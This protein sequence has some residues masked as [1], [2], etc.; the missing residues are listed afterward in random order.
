[1]AKKGNKIPPEKFAGY[2][3]LIRSVPAVKL[4]G[5]ANPYTSHN[6]H[7]F[8]FQDANGAVGIRLPEK[9]RE[10]F[11]KKYKGRLIVSYGI[12]KKEYVEVP[13]SLL[14]KTK[15]LLP[16]FLISLEYVKTLKPKK[17][18]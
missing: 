12:V 16:Y 7:M 2:K 17:T 4:K 9:D 8:T 11:I 14:N 15:E 18:K 10:E 13:E 1:M 5:D 6:G 3:E